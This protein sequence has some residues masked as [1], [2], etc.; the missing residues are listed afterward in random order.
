MG[1]QNHEELG[2]ARSGETALRASL[3]RDAAGL[4]DVQADGVVAEMA[5]LL[6]PVDRAVLTSEYG[7]DLAA[8]FRESV[9]TGVDGWLD[10]DLALVGD[11]GF[12]VTEVD[13]PTFVWQG[14]EDLMV[15]FAHGRWLS[16][17]LPR[18]TAH[19]L[20]REGH[21]SVALGSLDAMLDELDET[22]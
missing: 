14:E 6:P 16:E 4:R 17:H 21:L 20:P 8:A 19:L 2:A 7:E 5:S 22:L 12:D 9:R 18:A 10:D 15:P 1:E 3:E 11:W 13:V